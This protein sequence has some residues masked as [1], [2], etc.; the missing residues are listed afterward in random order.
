MIMPHVDSDGV[1]FHRV[2]RAKCICLFKITNA[3]IFPEVK[4]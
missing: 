4:M 1:D 2:F 3:I